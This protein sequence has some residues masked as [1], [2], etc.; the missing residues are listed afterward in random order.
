[1]ARGPRTR[2]SFHVA[3]TINAQ[4]SFIQQQSF[5]NSIIQLSLKFEGRQPPLFGSLVLGALSTGTFIFR[6]FSLNTL[7]KRPGS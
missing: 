1:M 3:W 7:F 4:M 5:E 6:R 2:D